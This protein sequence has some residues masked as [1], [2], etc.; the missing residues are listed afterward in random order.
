MAFFGKSLL[1]Q[2]SIGTRVRALSK[3]AL[4]RSHAIKKARKNETEEEF[5]DEEGDAEEEWKPTAEE[6]AMIKGAMK[7]LTVCGGLTLE[8][9]MKEE[10]STLCEAC[11][12]AVMAFFGK[13]LLQQKSIGT[14][15]RALSKKA[16]KRSH[17]IKKA[18]K[19]ET[20]EEF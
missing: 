8:G 7:N 16:L 15:V 14:R 2:K 3:K 10:N 20:E 6:I 12:D 19:N 13:S 1:Q 11:G 5:L 4:K 17:A 18:G 9:C